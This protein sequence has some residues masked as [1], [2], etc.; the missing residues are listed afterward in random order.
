AR[1]FR[2]EAHRLEGSVFTVDQAGMVGMYVAA[3]LE[4]PRGLAVDATGALFVSART[5]AGRGKSRGLILK[6]R[7]DGQ[8]VE[9]ASGLDQP[10]GLAFAPDGSLIATDRDA[11][12]VVR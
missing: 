5:R 1:R 10:R 3:S 2:N 11:H 7:H 9:T 4:R 8:L 6:R 12:G